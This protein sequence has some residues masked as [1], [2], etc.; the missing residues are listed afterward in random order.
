MLSTQMSFTALG[1]IW[2]GVDVILFAGLLFRV[3]WSEDLLR[4]RC[5][6]HFAML[7]YMWISYLLLYRPVSAP[8][9][10]GLAIAGVI[11]DG[12][13]GLCLILIFLFWKKSAPKLP[14]QTASA[15]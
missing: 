11:R 2:V 15:A 3:A 14:D 7:V 13:S 1:W 8:L 10:D 12:L 6:I 5:F 9:F 4:L